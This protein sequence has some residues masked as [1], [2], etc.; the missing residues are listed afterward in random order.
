MNFSIQLNPYM[1]KKGYLE[2]KAANWYDPINSLYNQIGNKETGIGYDNLHA[3]MGALAGGTLGY[4]S[5]GNFAGAAM[6]ATAGGLAGKYGLSNDHIGASWDN[7][8][9]NKP[10]TGT[11][12]WVRRNTGL[13]KG[14]KDMEVASKLTK[15]NVQEIYDT[16]KD[17]NDI[18]P[19]FKN[20][21]KSWIKKYKS[22]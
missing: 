7:L 17:S 4:A 16:Y 14:E 8:V 19:E 18:S 21:M 20:K 22:K 10:L 13:Y 6:G 15:T 2:K 11:K 3:G 5:T 9:G 1:F 12:N